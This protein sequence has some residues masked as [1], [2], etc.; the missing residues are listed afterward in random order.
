MKHVLIAVEAIAAVLLIVGLFV[1]PWVYNVSYSGVD[2]Q[3]IIADRLYQVSQSVEL[4]AKVLGVF[5]VMY[6]VA[7]IAKIS[8]EK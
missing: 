5:A 7:Q 6:A 3:M 4:L 8:K 1:Y 2:A